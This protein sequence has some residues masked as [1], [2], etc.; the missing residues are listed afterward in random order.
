MV[1]YAYLSSIVRQLVETLPDIFEGS[2]ALELACHM[3]KSYHYR[4]RFASKHQI[5]L[6]PLSSRK[7][8]LVMSVTVVFKFHVIFFLKISRVDGLPYS[9][10]E[11]L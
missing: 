6:A 4:R 8:N 11:P 1:L 5:Q 2:D 9:Q 3:I 10:P 7:G